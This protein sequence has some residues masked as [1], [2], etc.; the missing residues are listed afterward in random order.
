[1]RFQKIKGLDE[2]LFQEIKQEGVMAFDKYR[3][4]TLQLGDE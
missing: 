2:G 4:Y 3:N 1:M